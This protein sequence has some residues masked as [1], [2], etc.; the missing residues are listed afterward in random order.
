[1]ARAIEAGAAGG[2]EG[3]RRAENLAAAL[4]RPDDVAVL[5]AALC[6]EAAAGINGQVFFVAKSRIG[7]FRPLTLAQSRDKDGPWSTQELAQALGTFETY[8]LDTPYG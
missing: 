8:P 1:V 4:Q 2:G 7:L 6:T 3:A 5:I